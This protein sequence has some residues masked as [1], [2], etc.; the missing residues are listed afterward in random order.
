MLPQN[1]LWP[2]ETDSTLSVVGGGHSQPWEAGMH[3][4]LDAENTSFKPIRR[5]KNEWTLREH[6]VVVCHWPDIEKI[7]KLLPHRTRCAIVTF[8]TRCNLRKPIHHCTAAQHAVLRARINQHIPKE[9]I[10]SELGLTVQQITSRMQYTGLRYP[11]KPPRITGHRLM[12]AI[13]LRA[14][15]LNIS[16][17]DLDESC[18]S[19]RVF[20]GWKVSW[21][22]RTKH[23]EKAL[24]VLD[25]HFVIEWSELADE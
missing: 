3:G 5:H 17:K 2:E 7:M 11:R 23:I 25:G 19:G 8:A 14:F 4:T 9:Q 10:A 21:G 24:K 18:G 12:D 22:I 6:E 20:Q 15:E 1:S 13:R 16:M